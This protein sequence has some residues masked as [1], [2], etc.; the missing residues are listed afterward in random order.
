MR[1]VSLSGG[2]RAGSA[3]FSGSATAVLEHV[4]GAA[5]A[6]P[7]RVAGLGGRA[8]TCATVRED[9]PVRGG[10]DRGCGWGL[11]VRAGRA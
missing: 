9:V 2:I 10:V 8:A 1:G 4:A 6:A 7:A 3:L 11:L 5:A